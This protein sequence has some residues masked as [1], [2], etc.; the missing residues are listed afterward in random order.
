[1]SSGSNFRLQQ[2]LTILEEVNL[3][4]VERTGDPMNAWLALIVAT[5]IQIPN[6][7]AQYLAMVLLDG[8][9]ALELV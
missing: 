4:I 2:T 5:T 3:L 6:T 7:W 9:N 1:M 8:K